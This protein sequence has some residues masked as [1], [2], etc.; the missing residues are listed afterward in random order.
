MS[1]RYRKGGF[2]GKKPVCTQI[3]TTIFKMTYIQTGYFVFLIE[4]ISSTED[5]RG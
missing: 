1:T 2:K 5:H 3:T 4:G